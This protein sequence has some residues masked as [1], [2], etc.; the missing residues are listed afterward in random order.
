MFLA[1]GSILLDGGVVMTIALIASLAFW[2]GAI[3]PLRRKKRRKSDQIYL[4]YGLFIIVLMAILIAP[5]IWN[6]RLN[7]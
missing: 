3:P 7:H 1:L 6:Y 5:V 2:L 4:K